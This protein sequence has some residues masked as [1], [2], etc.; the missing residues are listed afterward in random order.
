MKELLEYLAQSIV[1]KPEEIKVA[2]GTTKAGSLL[3]TLISDAEDTGKLIGK[4]GVT[5]YALKNL[6]KIKADP[7][8]RRVFL[9][10]RSKDE[11][12]QTEEKV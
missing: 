5:A 3:L 6:L 4:N 11:Q 1:D 8:D 10:I 12:I 7:L 9:E 2:Q